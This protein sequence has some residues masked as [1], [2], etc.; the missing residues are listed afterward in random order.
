MEAI[1]SLSDAGFLFI[2]RRISA[3]HVLSDLGGDDG[4]LSFGQFVEAFLASEFAN[5]LPLPTTNSV[6]THDER[7]FV[8]QIPRS[9]SFFY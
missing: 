8:L 5:F 2:H 4:E 7:S 9:V 6:S 3:I 1:Q